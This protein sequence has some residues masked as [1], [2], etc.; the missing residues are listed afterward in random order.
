[1]GEIDIDR[2]ACQ[3][4]GVCVLECPVQAIDIVLQPRGDIIEGI[5]KALSESQDSVVIGFFDY[6]GKFGPN[7]VN[8]I[9][10][11]HPG[12]API[13]VHGIRRIDTSDVLKAFELGADAVILAGCPPDDDAFPGARENIKGRMADARAMLDTLGING[14][15]LKVID[16]PEKGLIDDEQIEEVV[17]V[18]SELGPNPLRRTDGSN[19]IV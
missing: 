11:D 12:I 5:Q 16:M 1:M 17:S 19:A 14:S 10:E 6:C 3:A 7:D 4:C 15:R 2:Y 18:I 9:K 13:L 8:R